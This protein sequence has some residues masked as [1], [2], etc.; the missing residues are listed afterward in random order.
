METVIQEE[1]PSIAQ[2]LDKL[3]SFT[4]SD[5]M[6]YAI[7]ASLSMMLAY[8][9]P[10][11]QG[12]AQA[13]TAA[14]TI[15]LIAAMGTVSESIV[16]GALR[17]LGTIVGAIVG[18]TLIA[19]FPQD[20][21]MY[22][23]SLSICVSI[24]LY[25]VRAYKGDP[26][27]FMLTAMTMMMVFKSGE[28]ADV[29]I[30]GVD[31]TYMTIFGIVVYTLVGIFLWPVSLEDTSQESAKALSEAQAELF[32]HR[33]MSKEER[34]KLLSVLIDNEHKLVN[35]NMDTG[36]ASIDMSQWHSLIYNYKNINA[37]LT[38]LSTHDKEHYVDDMPKYI[39]N[40]GQLENEIATLLKDISNV[41]E[42]K[43]EFSIPE[44]I[45]V[46]YNAETIKALSHIDRASFLSTVKEMKKLHAELCALGKKLNAIHSPLPTFFDDEKVPENKRFLWGDLEH[47]KAALVTYIIFWVATYFWIEINPFGGFMV[48]ALATGLSVL[49]T[50]TPIK[51]S[52]LTIV[53]TVSFI[54]AT[55]MYIL[56]L[57]N[58]HYAW[59]LGLFI[60]F[61]SFIAFYFIPEKVT[62]LF[63][64][65][66]FTLGINNVMQYEF[67][68]FL[69]I[70]LM[71]YLFLII[72]HIFYYVPFSTKPE[73]LFLNLKNRFFRLSHHL[74]DRGR[75]QQEGKH[76]T[77][78]TLSAKY[79]EVHLMSTVKKMQL[80]ASQINA[81]YF[82]T[83]NKEELLGFTKECEKFAYLVELLYRSDMKMKSNPLITTLRKE[84]TLP[85][86]SDLLNEYAQGK[87]VK[88]VSDFWKDEKQIVLTVET[89][90]DEVL[91]NITLDSY[92]KKDIIELYESIS[93]RRNVWL[94]LFS[95]QRMMENI[96]F[97]VLKRGRF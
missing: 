4:L 23:I 25:L 58:L 62:I 71:F 44:E 43:E 53:F 17:V 82:D 10:L 74:L 97:N 16:K 50:F 39:S 27:A 90:L 88:D 45:T 22:L 78:V 35:A 49:T 13:S 46:A 80:W 6:K 26:T 55:L 65:G 33:D 94:A 54:F 12:W 60:F 14:I 77:L 32:V 73:H 15:M 38:L 68:M 21:L 8:L 61:Y 1:K 20:R 36:T 28:V 72:L 95:C 91:S 2:K 70:L 59:E 5:K 96:D 30:F 40:Y 81:G 86:F 47:L 76:S 9:I 51:P 7:K 87:N 34:T 85:Y 79:S 83:I 37:T 29:F 84:Y 92:D 11:S 56:V 19:I 18:M 52:L 48:V 75:K 63:L 42:K 3:L 24:V 67:S 31:K 57:P 64:L 66:L 41:W 93:L 69:L 89:S